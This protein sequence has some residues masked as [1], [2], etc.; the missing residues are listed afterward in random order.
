MDISEAS[1][2]AQ[3]HMGHNKVKFEEASTVLVHPHRSFND[4]VDHKLQIT[5]HNV[6][7]Q[8]YRVR[9]DREVPPVPYEKRLQ[10]AASNYHHAYGMLQVALKLYTPANWLCNRGAISD[11]RAKAEQARITLI[12]LV[13]K[14]E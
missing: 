6:S 9:I 2:R 7:D 14:G 8:T 12:N 3:Q 13:R 5:V 11:A 10:E 4:I 1:A